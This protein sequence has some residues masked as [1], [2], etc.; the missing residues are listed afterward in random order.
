[1]DWTPS[2]IDDISI[3]NQWTDTNGNAVALRLLIQYRPY[4]EVFSREAQHSLLEHGPYDMEI[5]LELG[6]DA[7][8]GSLYPLSKD[9]LDL[10][11]KYFKKMTRTGKIHLSSGAARALIFFA[12]QSSGMLQIVV[13]YRGLNVVTINNKYPLSLMI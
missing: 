10:L 9:E 3:R 7:P 8:M 13:D 6:K 11:K 12:K 4:A 1:M 5:N 2:G